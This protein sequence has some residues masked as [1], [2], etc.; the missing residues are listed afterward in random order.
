MGDWPPFSKHTRSLTRQGERT[1]LGLTRIER[2]MMTG[3]QFL[4]DEKG[5]KIAVQIDLRKYRALWEDFCDGLVSKQRRKEKG[6]RLETVKADLM[7]R[8]RLR[9]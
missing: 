6:I 4:T 1:S 2:N 5:R 8:G 9:G 7:K 3:I